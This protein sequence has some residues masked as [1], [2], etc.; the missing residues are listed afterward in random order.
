MYVAMTA[1][2]PMLCT[3]RDK[4]KL[5][6]LPV[7]HHD[8]DTHRV[9]RLGRLLQILSH[10][11]DERRHLKLSHY[12]RVHLPLDNAPLNMRAE[13]LQYPNISVFCELDGQGLVL[14]RHIEQESDS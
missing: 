10:G 14:R 11:R 3:D 7:S 8:I 2:F 5:T 4:I 9:V 1:H 12:R 6:R 13:L